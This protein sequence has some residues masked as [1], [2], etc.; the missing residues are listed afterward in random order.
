MKVP[1]IFKIEKQTHFIE[2]ENNKS[3]SNR[4][5][6]TDEKAQVFYTSE[7]YQLYEKSEFKDQFKQNVMVVQKREN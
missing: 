7:I 2:P 6:I 3:E 5:Y 4:F 1:P